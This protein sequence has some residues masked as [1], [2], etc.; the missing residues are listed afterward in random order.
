[1]SNNKI[2]ISLL[3]VLGALLFANQSKANNVIIPDEPTRNDSKDV[4]ITT[5]DNAWD[6]MRKTKV[7]YTKKKGSNTWIN[8][9]TALSTQN[10][11]LAISR[12][13]EFM[14]KNNM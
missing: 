4:V 7:W 8:M 14:K 10:Y 1:M 9:Q 6:Y 5:H 3:A 2:A 12:L 13:T 11:Q